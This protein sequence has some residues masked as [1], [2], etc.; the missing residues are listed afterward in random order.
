MRTIRIPREVKNLLDS[1]DDSPN[2]TLKELIESTELAQSE[3]TGG[4]INISLDDDV[5]DSL[6][7]LRAYATEPYGSVILRLLIENGKL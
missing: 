5:V 3:I 1:F 2:R 7:G 4:S 6:M